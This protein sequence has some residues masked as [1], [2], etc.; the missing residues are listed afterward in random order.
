MINWRSSVTATQYRCYNTLQRNNNTQ[1][2]KAIEETRGYSDHQIYER[3]KAHKMHLVRLRPLWA[4]SCKYLN[5]RKYSLLPNYICIL[6]FL[7]NIVLNRWSIL[8]AILGQHTTFISVH[9]IT[10]VSLL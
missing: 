5:D 7:T 9:I 10:F 6:L 1:R 8:F 2:V 4:Y 3:A